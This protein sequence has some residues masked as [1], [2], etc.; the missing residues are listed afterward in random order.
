M[1]RAQTEIFGLVVIILLISVAMLFVITFLV[2]KEPSAYK[3][4]FQQEEIGANWINAFL[5]TTAKECGGVDMA[6]LVVDCAENPGTP[7]IICLGKTSCQYLKD[8][9]DF[10]PA[11]ATSTQ[12]YNKVEYLL[13]KS[14]S[15]WRYD[16]YQMN[17]TKEPGDVNIFGTGVNIESGNCRGEKRASLY[18]L[19]IYGGEVHINLD[20]CSQ[21]EIVSGIVTDCTGQLDGTRCS[22][23]VSCTKDE[24]NNGAC[25]GTP[26]DTR[27]NDGNYCNGIETC[28]S[29]GCQSGTS[30]N[31][32][33]TDPCTIDNCNEVSDSCQHTPRPNC[34]TTD[35]DCND[36]IACTQNK[37][38]QVTNSCEYIL[39]DSLC[40]SDTSCA[41]YYCDAASGCRVNYQPSTT[42]C[43]A[44]AG[45]CDIEEKCTGSSTTCPTDQLRPSTYE[46][47]TAA[48]ICDIAE[49][50]D[51]I[52][53]NCPSNSY[54]LDGTSCDDTFYCNGVEICSLGVCQQTNIPWCVTDTAA[55]TICDEATDSCKIDT[56]QCYTGGLCYPPNGICEYGEVCLTDCSPES[57]C[58]DNVDNNENGCTDSVDYGCGG[59]ETSCLNG[60]DD[61]CNGLIDCADPTRQGAICGKECE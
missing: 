17:F 2:K 34:C 45:V 14:L 25:R 52:N 38:N 24:C 28:N 51:G 3:K 9:L 35:T 54:K 20:I 33:D 7:L 4:E 18:I 16:N 22:D 55:C 13:Y 50:C 29:A 56:N 48:G 41:D 39:Q 10:N 30:I 60:V 40:P 19:P 59:R 46:C 1:S 32:A 21:P 61:N 37:C 12:P 49:N 31:C 27:C 11:T 44:A 36:N 57:Q 58:S 5:K 42:V 6:D 8:Q 47:R 53:A 26:D 15:E 23:G 43:K